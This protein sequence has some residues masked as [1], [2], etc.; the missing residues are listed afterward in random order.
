MTLYEIIKALHI[1]AAGLLIITTIIGG[2][3]I[4]IRLHKQTRK[5]KQSKMNKYKDRY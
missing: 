1:I 4:G 3:H 5:P 2:I